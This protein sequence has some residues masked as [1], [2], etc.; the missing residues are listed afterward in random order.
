M[1]HLDLH[2][3]SVELAGGACRP[4]GVALADEGDRAR[5][6]SDNRRHKCE[7]GKK[8]EKMRK[9]GHQAAFPPNRAGSSARPLD[10][11][12]SKNDGSTPHVS[13]RPSTF[14]SESTP[15]WM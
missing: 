3:K 13:K 4:P 6:N 1:R 14:P 10:L 9:P 11:R 12:S 2:E 7:D 8:N 15:S 5:Q